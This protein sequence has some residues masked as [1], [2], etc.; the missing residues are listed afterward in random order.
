MSGKHNLYTR[1]GLYWFR[2]QHQGKDIREPL[3]TRHLKQAQQRRDSILAELS[4]GK[5]KD[6]RSYTFN[7]AVSKWADDHLTTLKKSSALRY[8]VSLVHLLEDYDQVPIDQISSSNLSDF[9]TRRRKAGAS[10]PT[11]RRDLSCLSSLLTAC[12]DWEWLDENEALKYMR[13]RKK[14][15]LRESSPKTRYLSIEEENLVLDNATATMWRAIAFAI[16]TGMRK[17]E[18]FSLLKSDVKLERGVIN[19]RK[20]ITKSTMP[21]EVAMTERTRQIV[22]YLLTNPGPYLWT[23]PGSRDRYSTKTSTFYARL[24]RLAKKLDLPKVSWHD[25]RRT[26]GCRLLNEEEWQ[27]HEVSAYLGHSSVT[28]TES[29]YAFLEKERLNSKR[30]AQKSAQTKLPKA[31]NN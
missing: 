24:V 6:K 7:E 16:D 31:A 21:R 17:E 1:N 11:I 9:E 13:R 2:K 12:Q 10:N 26:C 18:Q 8:R 25:L 30:S 14:R 27:M 22:E 4:S 20:E 28:V 5:W 23:K 3:E 19:I 29:R 15:G